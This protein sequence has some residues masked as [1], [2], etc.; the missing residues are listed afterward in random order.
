M[1]TYYEGSEEYLVLEEISNNT[2]GICK[3]KKTYV[4][5]ISRQEGTMTL[6]SP[7]SGAD[8]MPCLKSL[9]RSQ[10]WY[11]TVTGECTRSR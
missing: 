8:Q 5:L 3:L 6:G 4:T 1:G 11:I 2:H 7:D 10:N 9:A